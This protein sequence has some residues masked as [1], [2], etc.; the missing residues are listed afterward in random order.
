MEICSLPFL[1]SCSAFVILFHLLPQRCLRQIFL[2]VVNAGFLIPFVPNWQSWLWLVAWISGTFAALTLVR[3]RPR[4]IIAWIGM[5]LAITVFMFLKRYPLL[6]S[7]LPFI[8]FFWDTWWT[9]WNQPVVVLGLSYMLFKFIHM[10]VDQSQGQLD[11]FS[12]LSYL[13]YQLSF[14]TLLAGPIQRYNDFRR[15]WSEMALRPGDVGK[16]LHSWNRVMIGMLKMAVLGA[17]AGSAFD[18]ARGS[19]QPGAPI[20]FQTFL[21]CFYAYPVY[22]YFNFSGYCDVMIGI[23]A[24][25]GFDLPENF[26]QP[27]LGRN[28]LDYWNRWHMSLTRWIR[29]YV[30]NPLYKSAASTFP[31]TARYWSYA[32][33]FAALFIA[34][35]WH[36]TTKSFVWFGVLNGLGVVAVQI[37]GDVLTAAIGRRGVQRY[38]EIAVIKFVAI[39]VTLHYV[40]LT[41]LFFSC[42]VDQAWALVQAAG[43]HLAHSAVW[44]AE[45]PKNT[46]VV[47]LAAAALL[48]AALW[49]AD[50]LE[51]LATGLSSRFR[52]HTHVMFLLVGL[53]SFVLASFYFFCWAYEAEAQSVLYMRF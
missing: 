47:V 36:G 8:D 42:G 48:A 44:L 38:R 10:L 5:G 45:I 2:G 21:T 32:A 15:G 34:G 27:Y 41:L 4:P 24:L 12:F 17:L 33:L 7:L 16:T 39:V 9:V 28:L 30:F 22:L 50:R 29:D 53:E 35:I 18:R 52:Q 31:R 19:L 23:A 13:N 46:M 25:L 40:F 11:P 1:L 51:L 20:P 43:D 3:A 37:Y 49:N 26:N 14:F 6:P